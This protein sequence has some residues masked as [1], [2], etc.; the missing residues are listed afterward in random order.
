MSASSTAPV[1]SFAVR[2][3]MTLVL[4][5][6]IRFAVLRSLALIAAVSC[7]RS[8]VSRFVDMAN[9]H[10]PR[11]GGRRSA[12]DLTE[13]LRLRDRDGPPPPGAPGPTVR[14]APLGPQGVGC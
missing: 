7:S 14:I 4:I 10:L 3:S 12:I 9:H 2:R 11:S 6:R 8:W 5:M 13:Q 1:K